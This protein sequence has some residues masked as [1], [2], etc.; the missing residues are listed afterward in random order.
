MKPFKKLLFRILGFLFICV[1]SIQCKDE[2][3]KLVLISTDNINNVT[4]ISANVSGTILDTGEGVKEYGHCW[5]TQDKPDIHD[6][7]TDLGSKKEP[8]GFTSNLEDLN[9]NV[10]YF[11]RAYASDGS[12]VFYGTTKSFNTQDYTIPVVQTGNIGDLTPTSATVSGTLTDLGNGIE[13]VSQHGHCWSTGSSPTTLD[14]KTELGSENHLGEF[15]S[16]LSSLEDSTRYYVRAYAI[17]EKGTAYG[18]VVSFRTPGVLPLVL[19]N[20]LE[21]ISPS[22]VKITSNLTYLGADNMVTNYGH[23]WALH[24]SPDLSDNTTD[25]GITASIGIFSS[26]LSDLGAATIYYARSYATNSYGTTYGEVVQFVT[27]DPAL[28]FINDPNLVGYFPFSGTA[29][30][31]SLTNLDGTINGAVFTTDRNDVSNSA[32]LFD[33]IDDNVKCSNS[34]RNITDKVTISVW[35]R[36]IT[37]SGHIVAKYDAHIDKGWFISFNNGGILGLYGRNTS[38]EFAR[39]QTTTKFNDNNWHHLLGIINLNTFKFYVD[40][41]LVG[42]DL[43]NASNPDLNTNDQLGLGH[44]ALGDQGEH[45]YFDGVIDDVLIFNRELTSE[46]ISILLG[47]KR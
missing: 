24:D 38:G 11:I 14:S 30:D 42:E 28:Y 35:I 41:N 23:C 19:D 20:V 39:A 9:P 44:W 10:K 17:N 1:I 16:S 47:S 5:D 21:K 27:G 25:L 36:S 22:S 7:K 15:E 29:E 46:E 12:T 26:T 2:F 32:L 45:Y 4:A 8:G 13:I 6:F 33:G 31:L 37:E 3:Q 18:S 40:G 43:L 34:N